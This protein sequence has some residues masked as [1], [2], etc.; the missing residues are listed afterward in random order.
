MLLPIPKR[1]SKFFR[2]LEKMFAGKQAKKEK[3]LDYDVLMILPEKSVRGSF[4]S[5]N[6]FPESSSGSARITRRLR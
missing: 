4:Y 3:K 6:L 2:K 1:G 5:G